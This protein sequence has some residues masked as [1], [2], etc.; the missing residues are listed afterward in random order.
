MSKRPVWPRVP[1]KVADDALVLERRERILQAALKLFAETGCAKTTTS[2]VAREAGMPVGTLY[3]YIHKKEDL[4]LLLAQWMM[5]SMEDSLSSLSLDD[6]TSEQ[7]LATVIKRTVEDM[8]RFHQV[9]KILHWDT[10]SLDPK[11]RRAVL[12]AEQRI[13]KALAD[14]IEAGITAGAFRS[15]PPMLSAHIILGLAQ[16]WATKHWAFAG[17]YGATIET[18]TERL[19]EFALKAIRNND[20]PLGSLK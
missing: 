2:A 13:V 16:M 7:R 8:Q 3:L 11:G 1:S 15:V 18:Y 5:E 12:D 9:L 17:D 6:M 20:Q 14:E 19:T 4:V 10:H